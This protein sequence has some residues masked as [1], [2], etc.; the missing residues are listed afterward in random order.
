VRLLVLTSIAVTA[1]TATALAQ[2]GQ[3]GQVDDRSFDTASGQADQDQGRRQVPAPLVAIPVAPPSFEPVPS[4][5]ILVDLD[6]LQDAQITATV[7]AFAPKTSPPPAR[8]F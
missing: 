5:G 1:A 4:A 7:L 8:W 6:E 3:L 2:P